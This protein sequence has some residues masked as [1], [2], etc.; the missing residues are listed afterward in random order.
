MLSLSRNMS[1]ALGLI[2]GALA[3]GIHFFRDQ[4]SG[5]DYLAGFLVGLAISLL[6]GGLFF[7]RAE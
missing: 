7:R 3:V 6:I 4:T 5:R 1:I 2:S